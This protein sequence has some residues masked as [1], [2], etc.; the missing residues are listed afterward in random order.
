MMGDLSELRGLITIGSFIGVFVL[1]FGLTPPQ[2]LVADYEG[3]T[4]TTPEYWEVVDIQSFAETWS[5]IMNETGGETTGNWLY[6]VGVDIGNHNFDLFYRQANQ[7][8]LLLYLE[9]YFSEWVILPYWHKLDWI[10][11]EGFSHGEYLESSELDSDWAN[12]KA[13]YKAECNHFFIRVF[14]WF[15]ETLYS[16]P[17]EAWNHHG[18]NIMVGIDFDQVSTSYNAFSL[19]AMLLFFQLPQVHW[20]INALIAIPIWLCIAYL[21]FI[22]ILRTAGAIF[23]GG[24]A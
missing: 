22:F 7:S 17:T 24:G 9:H 18:L 13:V 16:S 19:I 11:G 8:N 4:I 23:G 14:F 10:N 3:R 5:Y 15:N 12:D 1:L 6:R 20:I 2:L 21:A